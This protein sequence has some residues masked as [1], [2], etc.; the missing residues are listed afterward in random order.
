MF[1]LMNK[2]GIWTGPIDVVKET[3]ISSNDE[4]VFTL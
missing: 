2:M 4:V 1:K 3:I